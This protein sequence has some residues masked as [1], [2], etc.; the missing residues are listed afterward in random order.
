MNAPVLKTGRGLRS[1]ESSNLSL[2]VNFPD[3]GKFTDTKASVKR[4]DKGSSERSA[5]TLMY[6][7]SKALVSAPH[8]SVKADTKARRVTHGISLN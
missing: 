4:P 7:V 5:R 3:K 8:Q 6:L 2:S 1:L